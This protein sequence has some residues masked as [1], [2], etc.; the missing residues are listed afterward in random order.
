M[1]LHAATYL[2]LSF[3]SSFSL[4]S[5]SILKHFPDMCHFTHKYFSMRETDGF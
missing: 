1:K 2:A 5:W 4:F 3:F